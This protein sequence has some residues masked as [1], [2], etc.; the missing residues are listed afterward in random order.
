[1][2]RFSYRGGVAYTLR[3]YV[4]VDVSKHRKEELVKAVGKKF[5]VISN[6]KQVF[7][8]QY[9]QRLAFRY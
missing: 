1:M 5:Q 9:L 2:K 3:T 7:K 4:N 6:L 8:V